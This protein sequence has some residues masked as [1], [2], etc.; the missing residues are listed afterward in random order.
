M[1]NAF[2]FFMLIFSGSVFSQKI[3]DQTGVASFYSSKFNGLKTANGEKYDSRKFTAAHNTLPFNTILE[4][5]NLDNNKKTIVVVNDRGPHRKNRL[6]DL[7]FA[8]AKELEIVQKGFARVAIKV[9]DQM[10]G[11]GLVKADIPFI[12]D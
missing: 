9:L 11:E 5:T 6:I 4:V 3:T 1:K 7:S 8:A 12:T 2:I 10:P